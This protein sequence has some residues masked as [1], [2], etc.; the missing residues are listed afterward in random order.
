MDELFA[1]M[2]DAWLDFEIACDETFQKRDVPRTATA[3]V[4]A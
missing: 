1:A 3:T 2:T 4:P